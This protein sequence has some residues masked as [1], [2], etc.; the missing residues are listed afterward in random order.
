MNETSQVIKMNNTPMTMDG[1]PVTLIEHT[2]SFLDDKSAF[3][4]MQT[5]HKRQKDLSTVCER[6][7][8]KKAAAIW[9]ECLAYQGY[10]LKPLIKEIERD[11]PGDSPSQK[12]TRLYNHVIK[13]VKSWD[14]GQEMIDR[15]L[16]QPT[17]QPYSDAL[18]FVVNLN[19]LYYKGHDKKLA[20]YWNTIL[21]IAFSIIILAL[22]GLTIAG[23]FLDMPVL[24]GTGLGIL[25]L[26]GGSAGGIDD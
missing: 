25:V 8:N 9:K 1:V 13:K 22:I 17:P 23:V 12:V 24:W 10:P 19:I 7:T 3:A 20:D 26:M 18:W 16:G 15:S 11:H 14:G 5:S 21:A 6:L 4:W 2:A